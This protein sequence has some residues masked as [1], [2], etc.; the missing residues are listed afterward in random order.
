MRPTRRATAPALLVALAMTCGLTACA[1]D[2]A[3]DPATASAT[4]D[5]RPVST[6]QAQLLA[7]ARFTNFD[8]GTRH[9]RA[10][11]TE[12]GTEL[13][14][15]GW[16]DYSSRTGYVSVTGDGI[17]PAA[18]IWTDTAAAA[19][20]ATADAAGDPVLP[21]SDPL[22]AGWS[23][24]ALDPAASALDALLVSMLALGSDRPDNPLLLQQSGALVLAE[25]EVDGI[26]VTVFA[27]PPSD[28]P[29]DAGAVV[30]AD[31]SPLRLWLD[32]MGTMLRA[33][34]RLG[35]TWS[36]VDFAPDG[37]GPSLTP[38]EGL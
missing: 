13:T 20:P 24:R 15:Q 16:V 34:I 25:D 10:T 9:V 17:D 19:G 27:A 18:L 35:T 21:A 30:S 32:E 4:A 33:E 22:G 8:T 37:T 31:T 28:E 12:S 5:A 2:P 14:L 7:I 1:A 11:V 3:P 23:T 6:D 29:V 38:P 36:T 26:P